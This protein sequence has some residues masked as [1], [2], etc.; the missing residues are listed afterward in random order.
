M[1]KTFTT[2]F[3]KELS[4]KQA[5]IHA[6]NECVVFQRATHPVGSKISN[7]DSICP[8][9]ECIT[10]L[11][12]LLLRQRDPSK[13]EKLTSMEHHNEL[14]KTVPG[15]WNRNQVNVVKL[16]LEWYKMK[17]DEVDEETVHSIM[18]YIDVNCFEIKFKNVE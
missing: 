14:R 13:W 6:E 18:G 15:L 8:A 4:F 1:L 3:F 12:C 17:D 10:P 11:R 9:Y 7:F 2:I 16:L 5:P